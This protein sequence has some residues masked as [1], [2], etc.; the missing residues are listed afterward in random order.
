MIFKL[1]LDLPLHPVY[2]LDSKFRYQ[3]GMGSIFSKAW[4]AVTDVA[5]VVV[6][7]VTAGIS[8][9]TG[10]DIDL[11]YKTK[12]GEVVGKAGKVGIKSINAA[13]KTW[14]D[15]VTGGYASKAANELRDD[16]Y[17]ESTGNYY[18]TRTK[19]FD[20][21]LLS[22]YENVSIGGAVVIT[23]LY[24]GKGGSGVPP[25]STTP[26]TQLPI[27]VPPVQVQQEQVSTKKKTGLNPVVVSVG[28]ALLAGGTV[29]IIKMSKN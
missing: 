21:G 26:E 25:V 2:Q 11:N 23:K 1:E 5:K 20:S 4:N 29:M 8:S 14:A 17:K 13:A 19:E 12:V 18:E 15:S 7:P 10:K 16:E 28:L 3:A 27:A 6:Q 24:G 9:V 22:K